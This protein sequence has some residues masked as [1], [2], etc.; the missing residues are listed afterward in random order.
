M[1]RRALFPYGGTVEALPIAS[2]SGAASRRDRAPPSGEGTEAE[3]AEPR[4]RESGRC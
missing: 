2:V 1:R 4:R 3:R